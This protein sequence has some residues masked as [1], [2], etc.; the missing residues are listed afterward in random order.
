M[1]GPR[2][3]TWAL[4]RALYALFDIADERTS[5]RRARLIARAELATI[6]D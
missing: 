4:P 6:M 5:D 3:V 2:F 1:L